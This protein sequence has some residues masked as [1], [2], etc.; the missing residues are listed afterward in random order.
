MIVCGII[1]NIFLRDFVDFLK[2]GLDINQFASGV[3]AASRA[4]YHVR[5]HFA[6]QDLCNARASKAIKGHGSKC[7][8]P[9]REAQFLETFFLLPQ[10]D[11]GGYINHC[12]RFKRYLLLTQS[13]FCPDT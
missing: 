8:S 9:K 10:A 12:I 3:P 13:L 4:R 6:C 2:R 11:K 5:G 7:L 1:E